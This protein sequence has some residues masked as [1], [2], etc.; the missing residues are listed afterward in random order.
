MRKQARQDC[1]PA[2]TYKKNGS[3]LLDVI[4]RLNGKDVPNDERFHFSR[5]PGD[6]DIVTGTVEVDDFEDVRPEFESL[7]AAQEIYAHLY[8]SVPAISCDPAKLRQ[9]F[10]TPPG[11]DGSGAIIGIVDVGCDFRHRSFRSPSGATRLLALWDQSDVPKNQESPPKDFAGGREF[12]RERIDKALLQPDPYAALK[13][14]PAIGA[15][16]THVM[17]IAAGNGLEPNILDGKPP[18]GPVERSAAGVAP[19]ADLIFVHLRTVGNQCLGNSRHLLEAVEYIFLKAGE[20]GRPAVVNLSLSTTGGPHDGRTLVEQGFE[21]L[22]KKPD[23]TF[24]EGRALVISA[25]N[26]FAMGGHVRQ[27]VTPDKPIEIPWFLDPRKLVNADPLFETTNPPAGA[28][29]PPKNEMEIWYPGDPPKNKDRQPDEAPK[30]YLKLKVW[31]TSPATPDRPSV[32]LGPVP[33]GETYDIHDGGNRIGR[34]SHREDDPNNHDNQID[35][36]VSPLGTA[37]PPET[38]TVRL[39]IDTDQSESPQPAQ[40]STERVLFDAWIEQDDQGLAHFG[41]KAD[42]TRTLGSIACGEIPLTV[43][44]FD[45]FADALTAGPYQSSSAGPTRKGNDDKPDVSAPGVSIL[46]ARAQG[47]TTVISGTSMAAPHVTGLIALIFQLAAQ[48]GRQIPT[49]KE[50]RD[51]IVN[52]AKENEKNRLKREPPLRALTGWDQQLGHGRIRGIASLDL[53]KGLE[54]VPERKSVAIELRPAPQPL[55]A[56]TDPGPQNP[57]EYNE[58]IDLLKSLQIYLNDGGGNLKDLPQLIN[59]HIRQGKGLRLSIELLSDPAPRPKRQ[60]KA[61]PTK[62]PAPGRRRG[63]PVPGS[64]PGPEGSLPDAPPAG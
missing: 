1:S 21:A 36:R 31:L 59:D 13:Y 60:R 15:H 63:A 50:I 51:L 56:S 25:G 48:T 20:L 7:K 46:A 4:G 16:G 28:P 8:E 58:T 23:G 9:T 39:A 17:D 10:P 26:S 2:I 43:G 45:T 12:T 19:G 61:A 38:W 34:I 40:S 11:L 24:R 64:P 29:Q 30:P 53:V 44:A 49:M 32:T 5:R 22:L 33:L 54:A 3:I 18:A 41:D 14:T 62:K 57:N 52:G 6:G 47:G 42:P 55:A 37:G 27:T 35:I